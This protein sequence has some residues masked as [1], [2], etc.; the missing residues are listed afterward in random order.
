MKKLLVCALACVLTMLAGCFWDGD[1]QP[2]ATAEPTAATEAATDNAQAAALAD[3]TYF[4]IDKDYTDGW[5]NFIALNVEGGRITSVT[6]DCLPENG[7]T[8]KSVLA[9]EGKYS[10]KPAGAQ[11][12]WN[13]Q[14][15]LF[16]DALV[17]AQGLPATDLSATG[18]TDAISGVTISVKGVSELYQQA[19][20]SG[21]Q[22]K[23]EL[24]DG[25]FYAEAQQ[26]DSSG[27]KE[28]VALYVS[29]GRIVWVNWN[30]A[31]EDG[32]QSKKEAGDS[33]GLKSAS[34]IGAEW[35]QQAEAFE[36]YVI[37]HQGVEGLTTGDDGKTDAISG[38]TIAV[39]GAKTLTE[40]IITQARAAG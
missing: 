30:A 5:K 36:Q 37:E 15:K 21:P 34:G 39:S 18:T 10:M 3:G 13:E 26:F 35:Y 24:Q 7:S 33:Y 38:C 11:R 23:G 14:S 28:Y 27:Y 32:T 31:N 20:A 9:A 4:A 1:A 2:G 8:L 16:T 6:W 19:I 12:E 25:L 40:Q 17:A 29:G 22:P